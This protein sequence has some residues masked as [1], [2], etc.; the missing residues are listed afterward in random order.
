MK[1]YMK[2]SI[3]QHDSSFS[4]TSPSTRIHVK[5]KLIFCNSNDVRNSTKFKQ[6]SSTY[7]TL[8][9]T[10]IENCEDH[11]DELMLPS[12]NRSSSR[13]SIKSR[14]L[15]KMSNRLKNLSSDASLLKS[16]CREIKTVAS[17][18]YININGAHDLSL[19]SLV[20]QKQSR[21]ARLCK[22]FS[23]LT[24]QSRQ[25]RVVEPPNISQQQEKLNINHNLYFSEP[26]QLDI[27]LEES[28]LPNRQDACVQTSS[29]IFSSD[30]ESTSVN[31]DTMM[32]TNTYGSILANLGSRIN[33][34][35]ASIKPSSMAASNEGFFE[36]N[37]AVMRN[38]AFSDGQGLSSKTS[39]FP[40]PLPPIPIHH[41]VSS[42]KLFYKRF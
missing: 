4:S 24:S 31:N 40:A 3:N 17:S 14:R 8:N 25:K 6:R 30:R 27:S 10:A 11:I 9:T 32:Q 15:F 18:D 19:F 28:N 39:N 12:F 20:S 36:I 35:S 7:K 37:R 23:F 41:S 2:E 22:S 21:Y 42:S 26:S 33:L 29:T 13:I 38:K 16:Y 34:G 5:K 1:E